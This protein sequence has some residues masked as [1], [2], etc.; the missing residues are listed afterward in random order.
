[1]SMST[2]E[3][4]EFGIEKFRAPRYS[5]GMLKRLIHWLIF[6]AVVLQLFSCIFLGQSY[7]PEQPF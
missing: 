6:I 2:K 5:S 7:M 1:M 4:P 3:S